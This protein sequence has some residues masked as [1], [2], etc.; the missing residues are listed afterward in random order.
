MNQKRAVIIV[1]DGVGIGELPDAEEY[2]DKGADTLG[3]LDE[4]LSSFALPHLESYGLGCIKTFQHLK[5]TPSKETKAFGKC[6]ESSAAKDT[7]IGHWEIS[8]VISEKPFPLFPQGF[9]ESFITDFEKATGK[10]TIG[11]C[12]ASGIK[13]P[14]DAQPNSSTRQLSRSAVGRPNK[15]ASTDKRSGCD[16]GKGKLS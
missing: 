1:L 15:E 10:K 2:G 13:F 3:H 5:G 12:A 4:E 14:P 11:N 16:K 8:G 6:R 9:P 7:V